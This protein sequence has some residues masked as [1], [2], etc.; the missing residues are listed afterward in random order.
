MNTGGR[1]F[2]CWAFMFR[3]L[4]MYVDAAHHGPCK[5]ELMVLCPPRVFLGVGV[6]LCSS[7]ATYSGSCPERFPGQ[8]LSKIQYQ[9]KQRASSIAKCGGAALAAVLENDY[10]TPI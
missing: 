7:I 8:P 2:L 6:M 3:H 5:C 4:R 10:T 1:T 9:R